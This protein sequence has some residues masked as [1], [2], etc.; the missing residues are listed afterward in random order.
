MTGGVDMKRIL[1][2]YVRINGVTR[3]TYANNC[4]RWSV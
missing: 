2:V 4:R 1:V 3:I